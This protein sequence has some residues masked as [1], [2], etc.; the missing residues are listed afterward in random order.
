MLIFVKKHSKNGGPPD[1][2]EPMVERKKSY[3]LSGKSSFWIIAP[4]F[5]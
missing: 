2:F 1:Y 4:L 3:N 5:W